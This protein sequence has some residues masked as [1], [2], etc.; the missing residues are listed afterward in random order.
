MD[1][2]LKIDSR[3]IF[4][5][6]QH[7]LLMGRL[8]EIEARLASSESAIPDPL[9]TRTPEQFNM[10]NGTPSPGKQV[11]FEHSWFVSP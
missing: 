4:L 1:G 2:G 5:E 9:K 7:T 10:H 11:Q 6:A 8:G 3:F